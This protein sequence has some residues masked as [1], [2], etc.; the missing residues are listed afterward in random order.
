MFSSGADKQLVTWPSAEGKGHFI[1]C[2]TEDCF[3]IAAKSDVGNWYLE[4]SVAPGAELP[5][6]QMDDN[7]IRAH[8]QG[9]DYGLTLAKG[10][11]EDLRPSSSDTVFRLLPQNNRICL[12]FNRY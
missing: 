8:R 2:F 5:F 11:V 12:N 6:T 3:E 10:S 9:M 7:S 1:L 4:L